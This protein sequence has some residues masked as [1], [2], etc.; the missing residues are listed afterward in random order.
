VNLADLLQESLRSVAREA[1]RTAPMAAGIVWGVASVFVLVAI[2]RGFEATQRTA[3]DV[4]GDSFVLL[5]VNRATN[6]RGDPHSSSFVQLE[7]ED[8]ADMRTGSPS[9]ALL[10][11]KAAEFGARVFRGGNITRTTLIGVDTCYADIVNVPLAEGR[12]LDQHDLDEELPVCVI[13]AETRD[14]LFGFEPCIGQEINAIFTRRQGEETVLRRLTV[15][16]LMR[17]EELDEDDIYT[18]HRD[19]VLMPFTTWS[20][21][22]NGRFQFFVA[23]PRDDVDRDAALAEARR[24]LAERHGF[25]GEDRNTLV[26]YFDAYERKERIDAVFGG[27][28][29]FLGAVGAL[30]LLLGA[31]GVANVVL[32]SVSAR[33]YEFGL[34]R[35]V[36]C[37]R[38]WIF[39]QVFL[40]ASAVCV[41]SGGL[42]FLLGIFGV[43]LMERVELPEGFAEPRAELGAAWLP[44]VL[45]FA[46]SIGAA[47]WPAWRAARMSPSLALRGGHL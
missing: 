41:V 28:E 46:V 1:R 2:G 24:V 39:L 21:M 3:L 44:G 6:T 10:S 26:P 23:R 47:V 8:I 30:I 14:E 22:S 35:A 36:G 19:A 45:L 33:T 37:R 27:L 31:I 32:M 12:W 16:G 9:I 38:R 25:D 7:A 18:S 15:V 13:G 20:R 11:P 43:G 5:R 42:G 17:D 34:R 40:E 29:I 4:L